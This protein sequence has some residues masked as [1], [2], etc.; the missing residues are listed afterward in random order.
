MINLK[1]LDKM[2]A[3]VIKQGFDKGFSR[4]SKIM[5][6]LLGLNTTILLN[7]MVSWHNYNIMEG[8]FMDFMVKKDFTIL[9]PKCRLIHLLVKV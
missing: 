7:E 1:K 9:I 6:H 2:K 8:E 5:A 3:K 4:G